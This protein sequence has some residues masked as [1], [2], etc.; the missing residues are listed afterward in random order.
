VGLSGIE[1]H[2]YPVRPS[3]HDDAMPGRVIKVEIELHRQV[4]GVLQPQCSS[5]RREVSNRAIDRGSPV[6]DDPSDHQNMISW[7]VSA[8]HALIRANG[9]QRPPRGCPISH[10]RRW[11]KRRQEGG[12]S[13]RGSSRARACSIRPPVGIANSS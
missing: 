1:F 13:A 3:P 6:Q 9:R 8:F 12:S 11:R 4:G 2:T 5:G 7:D 10:G